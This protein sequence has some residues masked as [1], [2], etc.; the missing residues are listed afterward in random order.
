[1]SDSKLEHITI[2]YTY[3]LT[4]QMESQ[5]LFYESQIAKVQEQFSLQVEQLSQQIG[6]LHEAN[7]IANTELARL[8]N[9]KQNITRKHEK[10]AEKVNLLTRTVQEEESLN[11]GLLENRTHLKQQLE[12]KD[13][14]NKEIEAEVVELK[15][16]VR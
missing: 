4:S 7:E 2:E 15:E 8:A 10:L 3:L 13:A 5:R 1:M 12:A 9:E 11:K 14:L 16:Q 6:I